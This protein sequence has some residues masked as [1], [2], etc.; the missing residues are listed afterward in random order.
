MLITQYILNLDKKPYLYTG[1]GVIV[2]SGS[3]TI[4]VTGNYGNYLEQFYLGEYVY[5]LQHNV[6]QIVAIQGDVSNPVY[7]CTRLGETK[8]FFGYELIKFTNETSAF[9]SIYDEEISNYQASIDRLNSLGLMAS[10]PILNNFLLKFTVGEYV[11]DKNQNVWQIIAIQGNIVKPI[12][13]S[14]RQEEFTE[15]YEYEIVRFTNQT[16]VFNN[17]YD[18]EILKYQE[19]IERL[20]NLISVITP[21]TSKHFLLKFT[22]GEYVFDKKQDVWQIIAVLGTI[23]KPQYQA[24]RLMFKKLFDENEL[25]RFSN[26]TSYFNNQYNNKIDNYAEILGSLNAITT[27]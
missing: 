23:S 18:N 25:I 19:I 16:S 27:Y 4:S 11:L 14:T 20:N 17:V 26:Q 6:W 15:F 3:A 21:Q 10:P 9:N 22:V 24:A 12:F 1:S 2:L 7:V 5:D 13:V 8:E